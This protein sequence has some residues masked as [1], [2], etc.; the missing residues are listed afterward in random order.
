MTPIFFASLT[1]DNS[2][3]RDFLVLVGATALVGLAASLWVMFFR[4]QK[5]SSTHRRRRHRPRNPTRAE[6]GGMPSSRAE[7]S[8]DSETFRG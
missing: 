7:N 6:T 8:T 3:A 5:H 1:P 4:G 2:L